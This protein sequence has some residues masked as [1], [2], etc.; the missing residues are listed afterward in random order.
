MAV[1]SSASLPDSLL[2][3]SCFDLLLIELV[4]LA[5]RLARR[6]EES[7]DNPP[8]K[9]LRQ[10]ITT[11]SNTGAA[12][13]KETESEVFREGVY[14]RLEELGFR[15]GQGLSERFSKDRPRF[16]DHLDVIKFLCK[17]LWMVLFKKQVDNL[18]TNHRVRPFD[19]FGRYTPTLTIYRAYI[20]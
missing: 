7:L 15:V 13:E 2:N 9:P 12:T 20:C 1:D 6:Y 19:Y 10:P 17:D 5:E 3:V 16:T 11:S 4:P 8:L 14:F 18:K